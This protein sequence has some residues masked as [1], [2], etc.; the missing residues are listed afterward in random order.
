MF[1]RENLT[2]PN[3]L[4]L[5]RLIFLP[6]LYVF[7]FMEMRLAFQIGYIIL[8][9]TDFFD[10]IIAR[11][12]NQTS[13]IG[14]QMDSLA[15]VPF[16]ISTA[17]FIYRLYPEILGRVNIILLII[18]LS[19]VMLSFIVSLIKFGKPIMMHTTIMRLPSLLVFF[20]IV[21]AYYVNVSI[22]LSIILCI[23]IIG[24]LEEIVI[25]IIYGIVHPDSKSIYHI[26][27]GKNPH[28]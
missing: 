7:V 15:D 19:T 21:L 9:L 12:F 6:V 13:P 5:S 17:F 2:I 22:F 18:G 4:S 20:L 14:T 10:G 1:K 8:A 26:I 27:K 11:R 16:Y 28:I 25:F 3:F 24:F 23:Y